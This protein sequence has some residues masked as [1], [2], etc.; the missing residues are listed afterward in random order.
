MK[1]AEHAEGHARIRTSVN[2]ALNYLR[3]SCDSRR[4]RS[5]GGRSGPR[6]RRT[7]SRCWR[8]SAAT[9]PPTSRASTGWPSAADVRAV[10]SGRRAG[11]LERP[12]A[13]LSG[14]RPA[15]VE[16]AP[17]RRRSRPRR[18]D[19]RRRARRGCGT[20]TCARRRSCST[21]SRAARTTATFVAPL[22]RWLLAARTNGRWGTTHENAMALEALVAYYR[23]F[24]AE[25]PQM[26]ATVALGRRPS[27]RGVQ[28]P[29]DDGAQAAD[30]DAGSREA[31]RR[32][33]A[34]DLSISRTG[35][36]RVY[37]TA[38]V[39]SLV[40]EPPEAVDRGFRVERRYE[41]VCNRTAR[42]RR[43]RRSAR[44][45]RPRHGRG[46]A[47]RRRPLPRA[48]RS[49]ARGL[50]ADRRLVQDDRERSRREATRPAAA[51][52]GGR[53]GARGGSITSR[54]T[55]IASRVRDA[56]RIGASRVL[57]PR[58]RD[59][60][61]DVRRPARGWRRCMRRS[62]AGAVR[63]QRSRS[64]SADLQVGPA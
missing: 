11:R 19:G 17:D 61:R 62:S 7:R 47:P 44:R 6:R 18:G 15:P 64:S 27:A 14:R 5:S 58:A 38:R 9:R 57:V 24:E 29:I 54:S 50:R 33:G 59:D 13:A 35:T 56:A 16:R 60:G 20:R 41:R 21:A 51:T 25:V 28:R 32:H 40:P 48:H 52:T 49:A 45:Y 63:R 23:A 2:A 31:G 30:V 4:R 36:G 3:T 55:T 37:Y 10:V 34:A 8:S 26:T 12:R 22:A 39:Q 1:V 42:A 43:R 53:G 46:D